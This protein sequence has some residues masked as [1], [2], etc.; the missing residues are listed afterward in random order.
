[1]VGAK[2][3]PQRLPEGAAAEPQ[4]ADIVATLGRLVDASPMA[5]A[6]TNGSEHQVLYANPAF[7][8]LVGRERPVV[9]GQSL[10]ACLPRARQTRTAALLDRVYA[11]GL[12]ERTGDLGLSEEE[13]ASSPWASVTWPTVG[14]DQ[15]PTG[16]LLQVS[17]STSDR[18][19][20]GSGTQFAIAIREANRRLLV[21][22]LEAQ[23]Q[24]EDETAINADLRVAT[25]GLRVSERRY[26]GRAAEL[27]ATIDAI[28]D[29][30]A[31]LDGAENVSVANDALARILGRTVAT[32]GDLRR[33]LHGVEL[34]PKVDPKSLPLQRNGRW[35]EVRTF[36]AAYI[37]PD[38]APSRVVMIRD[39]T[40]E[41]AAREAREAFVGV[42]SH[43]LRTPVTTIVGMSRLLGRA[44]IEGD[45]STRRELIGDI[46]TEAER[47]A[48]LVEDL[49]VLSRADRDELIVDPEPVLVQHVIREAVEAEASRFPLVTFVADIE[50]LPPVSADRT[51]VTQVVR[52]LLSNAGKYGPDGVCEV[53]VTADRDGDDI[54]VQVLD[55]GPSFPAADRDRLFDL[56]FRASGPSRLKPGAGIGLY[57]TRVLIEAMD[58]RVWATEREGGGAA[59]GFALP[60]M[61]AARE[62]EV[63]SPD[64][65]P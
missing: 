32:E 44:T 25:E 15:Q 2:R 55:E 34:D 64:T 40:Q 37:H 41:R 59:F 42:L 36:G 7:C 43:E 21:A 17:A 3:H 22:G 51:Y 13:Q 30:V 16:L 48:R 19:A 63:G 20:Q 60:I 58:G 1:V 56:Y 18:P 35:L 62:P 11:T 54:V 8:R 26:L 49:L 31:V 57:V 5:I 38:V 33:A 53:R 29:G 50:S 52:N 65:T 9:V 10:T 39:V 4:P 61:A 24:A 27:Q 12:A 28:E 47:L 23:R 45:V 46:A 6:A 14:E